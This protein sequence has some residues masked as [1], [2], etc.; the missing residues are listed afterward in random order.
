M[1]T[2]AASREIRRLAYVGPVTVVVGRG[3][4]NGLSSKRTLIMNAE[5]AT[6]N[7]PAY[8]HK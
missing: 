8:K 1:M 5:L 2:N 7:R 4:D 3:G 6:E